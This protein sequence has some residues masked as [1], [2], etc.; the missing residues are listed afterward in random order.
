MCGGANEAL[1]RAGTALSPDKAGPGTFARASAQPAFL[2]Q[3][4][5]EKASPQFQRLCSGAHHGSIG[6]VFIWGYACS[7]TNRSMIPFD[8]RQ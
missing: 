6:C 1:R 4:F 5:L 2:L 8:H 7:R 3:Q